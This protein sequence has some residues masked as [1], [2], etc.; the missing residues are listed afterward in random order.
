MRHCQRIETMFHVPDQGTDAKKR[1]R[2][3]LRTYNVNNSVGDGAVRTILNTTKGYN[4]KGDDL[5]IKGILAM[6]PVGAR[7]ERCR[8][9]VV[10][11]T[12]RECRRKGV[13]LGGSGG[14]G[15][16]RPHLRVYPGSCPNAHP[17]CLGG[18][19]LCLYWYEFG[20]R[21]LAEPGIG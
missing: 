6:K 9:G 14:T 19:R 1:R 12:C 13:L 4:G 7:P 3:K 10:P 20:N 5:K 2:S 16:L 21:Q 18:E 8:A 15:G 11:E 17:I